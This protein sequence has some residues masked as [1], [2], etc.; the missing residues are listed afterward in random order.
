[1]WKVMA[2]GGAYLGQWT[3]GIDALAQ[4]GE[5]CRWFRD[6]DDASRVLRSLLED[7]IERD[8]MAARGRVHV[9]EHH[10]YEA[11]LRVLLS[12]GQFSV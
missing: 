12:G 5:H 7:R 2:C 9:L 1:M 6:A 11:R 10:T 4:D 3:P 8:A